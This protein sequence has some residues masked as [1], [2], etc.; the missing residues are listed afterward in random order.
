VTGGGAASYE[1]D[2]T[3]PNFK[4]PQLWRSNIAVDHRL[5]G[6]VVGTAEFIYNKDVNGVYY[7]NANLPAAQSAY[8]GVDNRPRW[9]GPACAGGGGVGPCV[10]R[11]NQTPG[12]V[13]TNALVLKNQNIGHSWNLAFSAVKTNF[14]GLSLRGAYSYGE[15][16]NTIDAGSTA[17]GSWGGNVHHG[18]PNNPGLGFSTSSPGHRYYIQASYSKEYFSFGSTGFA[19]YWEARNG[20]NTSYI[21]AADANGD[22]QVNDLIYIPRDKSEM[23]FVTFTQGGITFTAEQQADA[24]E[25]YIQQ[26]KYM[27][28]HR[29]EYAE[30]GGVFLPFLNRVDLSIT[31]D[32][33]KNIRGHRNA[34]QFRIDINNFGN[35]LNSD[36]G[37]GQRVI[38]NNILTTP[39]ADANGRLSYRMQVVNNQLL[40]RSFETTAS[41]SDVYMFML[42]FR[43]SFN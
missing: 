2:V 21:F 13:V 16:K 39:A 6:G 12:N 25:A 1:L 4:F 38:R 15:S 35:L 40:A 28:S 22:T 20:S 9:V 5:P 30:R 29:G 32:V 11:L 31:Q 37:V 33:F 36:W 27:R 23:N 34:G 19:M 26:D 8:T 43:Y 42:S 18:D 41:Q 17:L 7:I 3:D 14:H 10:T 24:F